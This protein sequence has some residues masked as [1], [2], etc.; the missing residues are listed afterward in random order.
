MNEFHLKL[1]IFSKGFENY[2]SVLYTY[3]NAK[4][5]LGEIL[6]TCEVM[7]AASVDSSV[8]HFDLESPIAHYPFYMFIETYGSRGDHDAEKLNEF[9]ATSK[10][11][12][13]VKD[14]VVTH[15]PERV[16]TIWNIRKQIAPSLRKDAAHCFKY[17]IGIPL[18]SFYEVVDAVKVRVGDRA[19]IVC[20]FGHVGDSTLLLNVS[21]DQEQKEDVEKL[22]VPFLYEYVAKLGGSISAEHGVGFL[23]ADDLHYSKSPEAIELMRKIKGLMDPNQILNPYKVLPPS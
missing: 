1:S 4:K 3:L 19:R 7:D 8:R 10:T 18:A 2:D 6:S 13:L 16:K 14:G 22:I 21:C 11:K 23:K 20:G 15:A 9:L 5:A 17:E 12:G